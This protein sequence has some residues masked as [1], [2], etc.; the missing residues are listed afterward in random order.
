MQKVKRAFSITVVFCV[1]V[2][3]NKFSYVLSLPKRMRLHILSGKKPLS[4]VFGFYSSPSVGV[5]GS[6]EVEMSG[7]VGVSVGG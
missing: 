5:S 4:V 1:I 3:K 7:T 6:G 2:P